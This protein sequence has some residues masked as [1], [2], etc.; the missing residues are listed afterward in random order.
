MDQLWRRFE[1]LPFPKFLDRATHRMLSNEMMFI[2]CIPFILWLV[3]G[4]YDTYQIKNK[5]GQLQKIVKLTTLHFCQ[6]KERIYSPPIQ[7]Q[8][9]LFQC[10]YPLIIIGNRKITGL[11]KTLALTK[12]KLTEFG[13]ICLYLDSYTNVNR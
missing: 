9:L 3:L 8:Y 10:W 4:I 12:V 2:F 1:I 5:F 7:V 11:L 13:E 6:S